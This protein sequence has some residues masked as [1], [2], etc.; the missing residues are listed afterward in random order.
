VLCIQPAKLANKT[1][2]IAAWVK[3]MFAARH[4]LR[5]LCFRSGQVG[6]MVNLLVF[7]DFILELIV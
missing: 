6:D 5:F 4:F 3:I 2:G 1:I 7:L